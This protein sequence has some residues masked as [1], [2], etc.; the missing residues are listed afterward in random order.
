MCFVMWA[1]SIFTADPMHLSH[2]LQTKI[3]I[4]CT[5][6]HQ[7]VCVTPV[8]GSLLDAYT[9]LTLNSPSPL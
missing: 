7:A 1:A 2:F 6:P 9:K 8:C 5:A 4:G 3:P